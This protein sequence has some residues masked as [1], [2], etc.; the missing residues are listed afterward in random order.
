M[1]INLEKLLIGTS[2]VAGI[3]VVN[4]VE[5]PSSS[6]VK[7]LISVL[8]QIVI[9]IATLIGLFKKKKPEQK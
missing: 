7:D 1:N 2:S 6:D 4:H 5:I 3:E 8:I 9:G